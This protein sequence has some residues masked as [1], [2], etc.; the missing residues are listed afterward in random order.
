MS[1][2]SSDITNNFTQHTRKSRYPN[3]FEG[4][5]VDNDA[6]RDDDSGAAEDDNDNTDG[7]DAIDFSIVDFN[8]S[9]LIVETETGTNICGMR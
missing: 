5:D 4:V 8:L 1:S 9:Q 2:K 3:N 6:G 7:F